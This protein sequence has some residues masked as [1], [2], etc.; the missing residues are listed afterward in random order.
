MAKTNNLKQIRK[1]RN[2]TMYM[3]FGEHKGRKLSDI[4][5]DYITWGIA[6]FTDKTMRDRFRTELEWRKWRKDEKA[7]QKTA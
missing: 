4:P 3:P 6:H 7:Q 5:E 1:Y 2:H